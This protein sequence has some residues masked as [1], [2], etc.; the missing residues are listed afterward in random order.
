MV[1]GAGGML[2][3]DVV[4]AAEAAGHDVVG[5]AHG[6]L[7]VTDAGAVRAAVA[8]AAPG[9]VVNC[10]AWT[11]VDGAESAEDAATRVN[12]PGAGNVAAA[13]VGAGAGVVHVSSDYVFD[14]TKDAPY[15]ES[16]PTAPVSA[17]GR[18]KLAGEL[19]V[20]EGEGTRAVVRSS[21]LFGPGGPNFVETMLRLAGERGDV[22]VVGDQI[23]CPTYT[24]H[25]AP[26][27]VA[28]A[29]GGAT[30]LFHVA[31]TGAA[32]WHG[33]AREI[34]TASG[35][36]VALHETT[37]AEFPRPAPRPAFSVLASERRD[38]PRLPPW[39]EGLATYLAER[40]VT[41]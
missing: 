20:L 12:G 21:W 9:A 26:A 10:A 18:G 29:A 33:F 15:V 36:A 19:A 28:L 35:V 6:D 27:L 3:R 22:R 5:L 23:G 37:T 11:D 17:Y 24:G 39:Q 8:V 31:G 2:G 32:S 41:A 7:D 16:D 38:A 1:T 25:L 13:A 4:R 34:F 40:K 30:G 14:G